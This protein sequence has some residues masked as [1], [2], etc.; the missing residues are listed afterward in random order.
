MRSSGIQLRIGDF[1]FSIQKR[2]KLI[3]ALT[4]VGLMFGLLLSGVTYV[5]SGLQSFEVSGAFVISTVTN[6]TYLGGY[7]NPSYNDFMMP[8]DMVDAVNYIVQSDHVLNEVINRQNL[9]GMSAALL[10]RNLTLTQYNATQIVEMQVNWYNAEEGVGIWN[11]IIE[12]TNEF[13]PQTLQVGTVNYDG[14]FYG[15]QIGGINWFVGDA[16][17]ASLGAFLLSN[18]SFTGFSAACLNYEMHKMSGFQLGGINLAAE[19][20]TGLQL[21]IVNISKHH[22]GLQLGLVNIN[23]SGFLPCFPGLNFNFSR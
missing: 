17:G 10:R 22:E 13:L 15:L 7:P 2:W 12:V 8:P 16:Y 23:S 18:N 11:A 20:S 4:L 3:V 5:Q 21:G 14:E 1:L 9:L 6:Q 19:S